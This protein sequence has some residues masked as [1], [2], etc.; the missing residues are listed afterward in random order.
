MFQR[1]TV[2]FASLAAASPIAGAGELCV[3]CAEP[4]AV[5]RCAIE[6]ADQL[7]KLGIDEKIPRKI[8]SEV[9]A[10]TGG[11]KSCEITGKSGEPCDGTLKTVG[12]DDVYKARAGAP[13]TSTVVPSLA[14]RASDAA[15][16]VGEVAANSA[17]KSWSCITSLFQEC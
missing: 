2:V 12:L 5:Y 8:C 11:H 6:K 13:D 9:L 7:D 1:L 10:R 4:A 17:Q 15:Q 14:D 16:S 3:T